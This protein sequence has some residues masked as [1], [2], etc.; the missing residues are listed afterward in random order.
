MSE[1]LGNLLQPYSVWLKQIAD[2]TPDNDQILQMK[3]GEWTLRTPGQYWNDLMVD[4]T[5]GGYSYTELPFTIDND[6]RLLGRDSALPPSTA[7]EISLG[8]TLAMASGVLNVDDVPWSI[9]SATPT[10]LGGYG[11]TDAQPLDSDLTA[12]AALTTESYG[13]GVLTQANASA[14]R[15]YA[16]LGDS[17]VL[18][19]GVA[20]GV[21]TLDIGGK[22]P[23]SQLPDSIL[24]QVRYMGTWNA[25]TNTPTLSTTPDPDTKGEYYVVSTGGAFDGVTYAVGDWIISNG[26]TWDKVDNTDQVTSVAG[27]IGAITLFQADITGLT[28]SDSPEFAQV[29]ATNGTIEA[30]L[31]FASGGLAGTT[32]NHDFSIIRNNSVVATFTSNGLDNTV[33]GVNNPRS[34]KFEEILIQAIGGVTGVLNTTNPDGGFFIYQTNGVSIGD[35]GAERVITGAGSSGNF[36]VTSRAGDLILGQSD[37]ERGRITSTGLNNC[38]IGATTPST[39]AFTTLKAT[40]LPTSSSG[41]SAGDIWNDGGTLKIV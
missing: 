39:G 16:G 28:T 11:I 18:N 15:T 29:K 13:R 3:G 4:P 10:T 22:I 20:L 30:V 40:S 32:S 23:S 2:L 5:V 34:A 14:L 8:S 31:S 21:A 36:M 19:A 38:A 41:L 6:K 25:T 24:G 17:A 33:I 12:I 37:T 35:I 9:V 7:M 1:C 27:R 26:T